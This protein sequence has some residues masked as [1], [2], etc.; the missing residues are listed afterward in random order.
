MELV[1]HVGTN[2][3][4]WCFRDKACSFCNSSMELVKHVGTNGPLWCFRDKAC[5]FCN[6]SMELV[7]HVG[8]NGPLW[9][10]RDKACSF[11]NSSVELAKHVGRLLMDHGGATAF[12]APEQQHDGPAAGEGR[13]QLGVRG[14]REIRLH[15]A[16]NPRRPGRLLPAFR[17]HVRHLAR[18]PPLPLVGCRALTSFVLVLAVVFTVWKRFIV[19]RSRVPHREIDFIRHFLLCTHAFW[20]TFISEEELNFLPL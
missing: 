15:V 16:G 7:K 9:C 1:K 8:T 5:S 18:R 20:H 14:I 13:G 17:Q 6:S 12:S 3:P 4:L 19:S 11:C 2:G 10:F